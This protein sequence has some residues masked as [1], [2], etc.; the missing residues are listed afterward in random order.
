[1][2]DGPTAEQKALMERDMEAAG[3]PAEEQVFE[4]YFGFDERHKVPLPDGK[5]WVQFEVMSEGRRKHYLNSTNRDV[6][7]NRSTG[8]AHM[9]MKPGDERHALLLETI[10]DWNLR[11]GGEPVPFTKNNLQEFLDKANP[12][13]IDKIEKEVRLKHPWLM[14]DMEIED[15][16]KEIENLQE[17]LE[18]KKR[19]QEGNASFA[20]K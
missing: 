20:T 9:S 6:R 18:V 16:E 14:A 13:I 5:S 12:R 4:D 10:C 1:M 7:I 19:E 15:I 3:I 2:A 11:R 8:D 17:M